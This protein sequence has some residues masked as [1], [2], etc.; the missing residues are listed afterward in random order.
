MTE[1]KGLWRDL[2]YYRAAH[3]RAAATDVPASRA[4]VRPLYGIEN[5]R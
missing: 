2:S 5:R 1:R 3:M 4:L